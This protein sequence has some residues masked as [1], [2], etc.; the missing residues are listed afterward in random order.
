MKQK[1]IFV[2]TMRKDIKDVFGRVEIKIN[3]NLFDMENKLAN[4][5]Q[6]LMERIGSLV[7]K[8]TISF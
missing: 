8:S 3:E 2:K 1:N 4:N 5:C 7:K 6:L